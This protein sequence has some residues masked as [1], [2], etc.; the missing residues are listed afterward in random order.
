MKQIFTIL[1]FASTI[2]SC[3]NNKKEPADAA[4]KMAIDSSKYADS[5]LKIK[6]LQ[7]NDEIAQKVTLSEFKKSYSYD[8]TVIGSFRQGNGETDDGD[9]NC[10]SVGVIKCA[11]ATFG[12]NGVFKLIRPTTNGYKITLRNNDTLTI[13]KSEIVKTK[14]KSGFKKMYHGDSGI[15]NKAQFMYAVLIKRAII[16]DTLPA[17]S[18]CKDFESSYNLLQGLSGG[19]DPTELPILL[20]LGYISIPKLKAHNYLGHVFCNAYHTVF[21]TLGYF[22]DYGT[23]EKL[24][25]K[26]WLKHVGKDIFYSNS[27]QLVD[28]QAAYSHLLSEHV[29]NNVN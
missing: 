12:E 8:T 27:F 23:P 25:S 29:A 19:I 24:F 16:L 13:L 4:A 14:N 5:L 17:F 1:A 7:L 9:Y 15:Y 22:D 26:H 20:G 3:G 11:I 21:I 18:K 28:M 2:I 6:N 10:S